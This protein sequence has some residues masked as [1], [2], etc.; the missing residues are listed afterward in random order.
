MGTTM[1]PAGIDPEIDKF[2]QETL[3]NLL[4]EGNAFDTEMILQEKD[5]LEISFTI[6]PPKDSFITYGFEYKNR[7]WQAEPFDPFGWMYQHNEEQSGKIK[8]PLQRKSK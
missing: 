8:N 7:K 1:M 2:N 4:N 3:L 5:R 6:G